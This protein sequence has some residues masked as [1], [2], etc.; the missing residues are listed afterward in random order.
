MKKILLIAALFSFINLTT[1]SA[2]AGPGDF[3]EG[4]MKYKILENGKKD[5]TSSWDEESQILTIR[6]G[7]VWDNY[8]S[9]LH[10]NGFDLNNT[11]GG[12]SVF[13]EDSEGCTFR[14]A[15]GSIPG[16][17]DLEH[18]EIFI[19]FHGSTCKEDIPASYAIPAVAVH[20]YDVHPWN[21]AG[22]VTGVFRL[23]LWDAP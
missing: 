10:A 16:A 20:F 13:P 21:S 7:L 4:Q 11:Q 8:N 5:F 22:E 3:I 6:L 15:Y 2:L 14:K 9:E 1:H 19:E 17:A 23:Q 12:R 18:N